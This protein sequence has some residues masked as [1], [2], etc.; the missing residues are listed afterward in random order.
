MK[1]DLATDPSIELKQSEGGLEMGGKHH[2]SYQSLYVPHAH[3]LPNLKLKERLVKAKEI[4]NDNMKIHET[5][6]KVKPSVPSITHLNKEMA[7]HE[8]LRK[9]LS[10]NFSHQEL[11]ALKFKTFQKKE[12]GDASYRKGAESL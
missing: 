7:K 10:G 8:Q 11:A 4:Y 5:L 2:E 12:G 1:R 3:N 9:K 6:T